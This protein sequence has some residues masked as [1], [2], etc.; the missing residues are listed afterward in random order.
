MSSREA[1]DRPCSLISNRCV[2]FW[3]HGCP[4]S[5]PGGFVSLLRSNAVLYLSS[6]SCAFLEKYPFGAGGWANGWGGEGTTPSVPWDVKLG[7][8]GAPITG[9]ILKV[10]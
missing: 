3:S 10:L 9:A 8:P 7:G 5:G 2:P 6:S 1:H 4:T